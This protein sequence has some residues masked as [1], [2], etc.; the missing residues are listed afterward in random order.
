[1]LVHASVIMQ[2]DP[3]SLVDEDKVKRSIAAQIKRLA[4][5]ALDASNDY[6]VAFLSLSNASGIDADVKLW[7]PTV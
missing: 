2:R 5:D 4:P 7:K 3:V 1:M 6:I